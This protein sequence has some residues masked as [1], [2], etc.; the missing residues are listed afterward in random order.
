MKEEEWGASF[1][2]TI[3]KIVPTMRQLLKYF[4]ER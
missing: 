2:D 3:F 1:Q 4:P